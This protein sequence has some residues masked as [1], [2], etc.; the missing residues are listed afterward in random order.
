MASIGLAYDA[1]SNDVYDFIVYDE[2]GD[3]VNLYLNYA[4]Y[5]TKLMWFMEY[6]FS[7]ISMMQYN[8][9]D[10]QRQDWWI[11]SADTV[12]SC[13]NDNLSGLQKNLY[14]EFD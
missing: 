5:F 13:T 10:D 12:Y 11:Y 3:Q 6:M 9:L 1:V 8:I 14:L 7:A 4:N 2:Y